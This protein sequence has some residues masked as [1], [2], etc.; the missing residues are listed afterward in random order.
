MGQT[1]RE[2]FG[3]PGIPEGEGSDAPFDFDNLGDAFDAAMA[4]RPPIAGAGEGQGEP[5]PGVL[6]PDP[7]QGAGSDPA[8]APPPDPSQGAGDAGEPAPPP[9]APAESHPHRPR[10]PRSTPWPAST[11]P[12]GPSWRSC[13][14]RSWPTRSGAS[15]FFGQ[16]WGRRP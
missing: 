8:P 12:L 1:I 6:V 15:R 5:G 4:N 3:G 14:R 7:G 9:A 13:T 11:R 10:S 16:H 2:L